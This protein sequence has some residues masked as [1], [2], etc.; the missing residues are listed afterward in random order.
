M[1]G[2]SFGGQA[3]SRALSRHLL[4]SPQLA[5]PPAAGDHQTAQGALG[6]APAAAAAAAAAAAPRRVSAAQARGL[7]PIPQLPRP[8]PLGATRRR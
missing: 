6:S 8:L 7:L 2:F 1:P 4:P 3:H 5:A